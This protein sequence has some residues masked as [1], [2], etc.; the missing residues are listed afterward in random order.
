MLARF[1]PSPR[2]R[3]IA[4]QERRVSSELPRP[5]VSPPTNVRLLRK[6]RGDC[7]FAD[8]VDQSCL[9]QALARGRDHPVRPLA[10]GAGL[11]PGVGPAHRNTADDRRSDGRRR[12]ISGS[13]TST[14][15]ISCR[16]SSSTSRRVTPRSRCCSRR[17]ATSASR[18]SSSRAASRSP[19]CPTG[20]SRRSAASRVICG[21][22][23]F[24]DSWLHLT[25][26]TESILN[27][28]DCAEGDDGELRAIARLTG[29]ID[30]LLTQFS[31]AAWKGG[32][33]NAH[34]RKLAARA[35]ARD[36]RGADPRAR[37]APCRAVREPGLLLQRGEFLSQRSRQPPADAAAAIAQGRR[38]AADPVPRRPLGRGRAVR[39]RRRARGLRTAYDE[40]AALPLR[41]P[42]ESVAL[43]AARSASLPPIAS[44]SSGR[45]RSR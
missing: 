45:I 31:Y 14:P 25:D 9:R 10:R 3:T 36:D 23:E 33:A 35:Q 1:A 39:Q 7:G 4:S 30:V 42:G 8:H 37:A 28:N 44:A 16:S 12:P 26:G 20:A 2:A 32:R 22:S 40:M 41:P 6:R 38:R 24:Y 27:L 13:R 17:P 21:V 29:P 34:F 11:Q 5:V 19:S 15:T 43:R 18:R